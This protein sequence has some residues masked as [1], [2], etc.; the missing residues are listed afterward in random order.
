MSCLQ[1]RVSCN[2]AGSHRR[3]RGQRPDYTRKQS[4]TYDLCSDPNQF[5]S[6][7]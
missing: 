5:Q 3:L 7:R 4:P 6:E 1:S 2:S